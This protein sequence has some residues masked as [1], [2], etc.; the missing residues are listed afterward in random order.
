MEA[1]DYEVLSVREQL[2]HERVR[3]CIVS[4]GPWRGEAAVAGEGSLGSE[5]Q[6]AVKLCL[7]QRRATEASVRAEGRVPGWR[8][9]RWDQL[10]PCAINK[11]RRFRS[12]LH[13]PPPGLPSHHSPRASSCRGSPESE[14]LRSPP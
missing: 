6:S 12:S 8:T 4:A 3:E 10:G 14:G 5:L 7:D 2:F 9:P 11:G 1:A 13:A